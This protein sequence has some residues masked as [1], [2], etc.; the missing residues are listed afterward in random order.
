ME[1]NV[2]EVNLNEEEICVDC[3]TGLGYPKGTPIELRPFYTEGGGD[4][5][6]TC[7]RIS[8]LTREI[9]EKTRELE[10]LQ[11]LKAKPRPS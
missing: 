9:A 4:R 6:P 5:C 7:V 1:K 2:T 10:R 8:Q 11:Q 3:Q